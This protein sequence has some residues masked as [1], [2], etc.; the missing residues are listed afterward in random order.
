M[1]WE[2]GLEWL[3]LGVLDVIGLSW[4]EDASLSDPSRWSSLA[5]WPYLWR[6]FHGK[7]F[8]IL[9]SSALFFCSRFSRK[10]LQL[11]PYELLAR[12]AFNDC[13]PLLDTLSLESSHCRQ[14]A[15]NESYF[16]FF[17]NSSAE[18]GDPSLQFSMPLTLAA[19]IKTRWLS[20]SIALDKSINYTNGLGIKSAPCAWKR[21]NWD[22]KRDL[23][24]L[25]SRLADG[26]LTAE[27]PKQCRHPWQNTRH[28]VYVQ[29]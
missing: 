5:Q 8:F 6:L 16:T 26:S 28:C 7:R 4:Q 24:F 25:C 15:A 29:R 12:L 27:N 1:D 3:F 23:K 19:R 13:D 11:L 2:K 10:R 9:L 17:H 14:T 18:G 22:S 21:E 20:S